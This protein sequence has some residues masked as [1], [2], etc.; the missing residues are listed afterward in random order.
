M[1]L[2]V[3]GHT[4]RQCASKTVRQDRINDFGC[5]THVDAVQQR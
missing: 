1:E 5:A 2:G 4:A 3:D